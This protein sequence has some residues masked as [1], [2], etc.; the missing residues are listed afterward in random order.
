M[1]QSLLISSLTELPKV[2]Q[3]II[4]YFPQYR[5]FT[6]CGEIG[7]GKTTLIREI[8]KILNVVETITS[9]TFAIINEYHT[10][11][12]MEIAHVDCYRIKNCAEILEIGMEDYLNGQKT[13]WIEWP[14]KIEE[15]LVDENRVIINIVVQADGKREFIITTSDMNHFGRENKFE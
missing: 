11:T 12:D 15:L 6:F 9:P 10:L 5:I 8:G 7:S 3:E 2:A 1:Q 4:T 14:E 13:L